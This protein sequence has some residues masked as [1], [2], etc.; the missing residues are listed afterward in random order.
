MSDETKTATLDTKPTAPETKP[1]SG[2]TKAPVSGTT[3][4][5]DFAPRRLKAITKTNRGT[6]L[7]DADTGEDLRLPFLGEPRVEMFGVQPNCHV[8]LQLTGVEK[9]KR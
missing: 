9:E 4:P 6:I 2:E 3:N 1:A 7:V 8:S 5:A